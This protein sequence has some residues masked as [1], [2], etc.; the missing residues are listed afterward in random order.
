[1]E[2][3]EDKYNSP[4]KSQKLFIGAQICLRI[5]TI[6][7][8]LAATWIM[9]TDKQ[10]I[11]F[12]DFVMV[13]KYNYSSAFKFFV[14]ANVIACACSVVSLLFLCALGRYSSNPGHVFLLFLHDLLMMSL[15]LAG[16]SA[17]TAIGFLGKYGN[18]KSGWMPI[19]DQFGQFCNR[20][21][22]SMMLSYLSMV[23][24]LIL[25][26]TSANKSRQIHV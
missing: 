15:V 1:M 23:C 26:V 2:N 4:L 22:I 13:A 10:S 17:A 14:L 3:V 11:T 25:T 16:C 12:G 20:G 6:G 7:A 19:C 21:T 18:T 24:L 9:V 8:T 5:V